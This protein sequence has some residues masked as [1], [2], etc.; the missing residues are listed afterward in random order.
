MGR[1]ERLTFSDGE[2]ALSAWMDEH[3]RVCWY[4]APEPWLIES[5]LISELVLPLNLDKNKHSGFHAAL[6]VARQS[7][8]ETA[9][10]LPVLLR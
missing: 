8:R 1:T 4:V 6:T 9:R 5:K 3:A 2:T 7:Q 10:N